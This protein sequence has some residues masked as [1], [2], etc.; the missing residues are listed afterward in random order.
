MLIERLLILSLLS[1]DKKRCVSLKIGYTSFLLFK[2]AFLKNGMSF[3]NALNCFLRGLLLLFHGQGTF[4]D[5][6]QRCIVVACCLIGGACNFQ[7]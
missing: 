7:T 2:G 1:Q 5:V 6:G 3:R 4:Y